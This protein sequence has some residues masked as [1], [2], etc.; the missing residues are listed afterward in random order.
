MAG[1]RA[2]PKATQSGSRLEKRWVTHQSTPGL[3][4]M[5]ELKHEGGN[6][7]ANVR[8]LALTEHSVL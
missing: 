3:T 4:G 1:R 6:Q 8:S 2:Q 7:Q 5:K